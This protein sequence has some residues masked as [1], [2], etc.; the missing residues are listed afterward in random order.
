[1]SLMLPIVKGKSQEPDRILIT[2]K[3][4]VGKSTWAAGS[5]RP[6]F[7]DADTGSHQ[8]DV[9]RIKPERW[10]DILDILR[11]WPDEFQTVVVDSL[12]SAETLLWRGVLAKFGA[13]SPSNVQHG[14]AWT[15]ISSQWMR[16]RDVLEE[17][18][19]KRGVE[20]ILIGHVQKATNDNPTGPDFMKYELAMRGKDAAPLVA[21]CSTAGFAEEEI[22]VDPKTEKARLTPNRVLRFRGAAFDGK[23]RYAVGD[24]LAL[25]YAAYAEARERC[26][27]KSPDMLLCEAT[28]L[29]NDI[30][31]DDLADRL[32]KIEKHRTNIAALQK[33]ID[34]LR[35]KLVTNPNQG[36]AS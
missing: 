21:W 22:V 29:A 12:T 4:G 34:F 10:S 14:A 35:T 16:L 3:P 17:L 36:V 6:L 18:Q 2:G 28:R 31:G 20:V 32:S 8:L 13:D 7:I 26:G 11:D 24:S 27:V 15:E 19:K 30:G 9:A 33:W 1:M 5:P 23:C 25:S